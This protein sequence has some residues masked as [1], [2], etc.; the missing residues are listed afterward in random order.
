MKRLGL[1]LTL[2]VA[3]GRGAGAKHGSGRLGLGPGHP[4]PGLGP[5][6]RGAHRGLRASATNCSTSP[7]IWKSSRNWQRVT[8]L[9]T[10]ALA[11]T[12]EL[13]EGVVFHDGTPFDAEAVK[14]NIERSKT[15]PGSNRASELEQVES[16]EVVD[17]STVR[18]NLAQPFA[19]LVALLADRSG[20][21]VSPSA[22]EAEGEDFGNNPVCA[23]T[24]P[25]RRARVARPHRFG[26]VRGLLERREH[27]Y[28]PNRLF[29]DSRR[30]R[31]LSKLAVRRFATHGGCRRDRPRHHSQRPQ[32]RAA[33]RAEFGLCGHHPQPVQPRP[34][35]QPA[36]Q[37]PAHP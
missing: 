22:A 26:Q 33:L 14:Y 36:V 5:H 35:R 15:L 24:L 9:P 31:A 10:T 2:L 29:T 4:R 21:M 13:R 12:I 30:E 6:L 28:R 27:L 32:L 7:R 25:V 1:I 23:G 20:M 8:R 19:P 17:D 16:V 18:L 11:L 34:A 37:R 3:A